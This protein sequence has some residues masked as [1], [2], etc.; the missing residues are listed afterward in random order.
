MN[1]NG[2]GKYWTN[3]LKHMS[4]YLENET[5]NENPESNRTS[6]IQNKERKRHPTSESNGNQICNPTHFEAAKFDKKT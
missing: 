3:G 5:T 4:K 6:K 1:A 2:F